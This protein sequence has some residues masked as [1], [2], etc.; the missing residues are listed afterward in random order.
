M[1]KKTLPGQRVRPRNSDTRKN[2]GCQATN[3]TRNS[4]KQRENKGEK[5][6][7]TPKGRSPQW[8]HQFCYEENL[9]MARG[10]PQ[11]MERHPK[12]NSNLKYAI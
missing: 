2:I 7:N 12:I 8:S 5:T 9:S 6:P 4:G 10:K 3:N 11:Q 1:S